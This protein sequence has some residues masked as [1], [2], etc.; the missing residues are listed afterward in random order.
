M[1][2]VQTDKRE[3][4][5]LLGVTGCIAA[6]KSCEVLRGLQRRGYRVKVVMTEHATE[7]VGPTTF[8]ALSGEPVATGLFDEAGAPIHHI[9]LAKEADLFLI[10]PATANVLAKLAHG[11]ADDLL[12]TTA[13][14]TKARIAVAPA[15]NVEMWRNPS[16]QEAVESLRRRGAV[17]IGPDSGY[18]SCGDVGAGRMAEPDEI[19]A[20][21][22]V[23]LELGESLA[24]KRIMVTSGPTH[25]PIDPV[26]FIG[27]RSSGLTG[28]QIAAEA[29]ARGADVTLVTGPVSLPDPAGVRTVHVQTALE[30]LDAAQEA[31]EDCDAAVFCAA[32]ADFRPVAA[33]EGKIK[34]SSLGEGGLSIELVENPDIIKTLAAGKGERF[35]VGFAAE[36][37]DV[38]AYAQRKLVEKNADVIVANDVS[39]PALGFGTENNRVWFVTR[40][41]E[42]EDSGIVPKARIAELVVDRISSALR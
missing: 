42:P 6:Y 10:A 9:S 37:G 4:T 31:F 17:V 3:R 20:R 25:E 8:R 41:G 40:D 23:L 34:K 7:F 22:S 27:N 28:S 12:T 24:G 21:A 36:T 38:I 5:V 19:V 30:M 15:M 16:T 18:L 14:A 35:V 33:A 26:R 1:A 13:L 29:A 32:V 39:D 11:I 2:T